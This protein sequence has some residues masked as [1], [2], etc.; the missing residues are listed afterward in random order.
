MRLTWTQSDRGWV[1]TW[2][3]GGRP[4]ALRVEYE[5]PEPERGRYGL[6]L[7][8]EARPWSA[9][10][11]PMRVG[12]YPGPWEAKAHLERIALGAESIPRAG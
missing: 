9:Y 12:R 2:W 1:A 6:A 7:T 10:V 3:R 11:G 4:I 5:D 8:S